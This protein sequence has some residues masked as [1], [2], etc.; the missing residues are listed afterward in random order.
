[1]RKDVEDE[2]SDCFDPGEPHQVIRMLFSGIYT[3]KAWCAPPEQSVCYKKH[4]PN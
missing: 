2:Y 1:M 3:N 4:I